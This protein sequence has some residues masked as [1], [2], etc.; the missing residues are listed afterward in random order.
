[1]TA[2][3]VPSIDDIDYRRWQR[4]P[5]SD[6]AQDMHTGFNC[7]GLMRAFLQEALGKDV[8]AI[9][10]DFTNKQ[11]V[12]AEADRQLGRG[13]WQAIDHPE[14]FCAVQMTHAT[15][16]HHVGVW[17]PVNGGAVLHTTRT[18]G[19]LIQK[20]SLLPLMGFRITGFYRFTG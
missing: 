17:V 20:R 3:A 16:A 4:L 14:P 8:A 6:T 2:N 1:M 10:V 7:W 5:Y 11:Q 13:C 12:A 19:S 9:D 18:A 15:I